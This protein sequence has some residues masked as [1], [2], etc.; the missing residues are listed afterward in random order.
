MREEQIV[1]GYNAVQAAI[2]QRPQAIIRLFFT[3]E[4]APRFGR[5]CS[6]MA[7]S[8]KIYRSVDN[9]ELEKICRSSHHGGVVG[10]FEAKASR[11]PGSSDVADWNDSKERILV[12]DGISNTHNMGAMIRTAAFLGIRHIL[13]DRKI[14]SPL[15]APSASRIAEGGLE[16]V[17][18]WV[19]DSVVDFITTHKN[20]LYVVGTDQHARLSLNAVAEKPRAWEGALCLV[21]GNEEEGMCPEM[22]ALCDDLMAIP[23]SGVIESL[24]VAQAAAICMYALGGKPR[25]VEKAPKPPKTKAAPGAPRPGAK[26]ARPAAPKKPGVPR[27]KQVKELEE[28]THDGIKVKKKIYRITKKS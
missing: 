28:T 2:Q 13:V 19:V 8:K 12:F 5:I 20:K 3:D 24:N 17:S 26:A 4:M 27:G 22:R 1:Y 7:K 16:V 14:S 11:E 15:L 25:V 6:E 18:M 21:M 10:V 9:D 23:G